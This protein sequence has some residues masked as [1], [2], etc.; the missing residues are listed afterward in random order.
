MRIAIVSP[1]DFPYPGGVTKHITNLAKSLRRR[2]HRVSIIAASSRAA[3]EIP[4]DVIRVSRFVVPVRYSGSVARISPLPWLAHRVHALLRQEAFDV[5]HLH[6]PTTP[7][8]PWAVTRHIRRVSPQTAL[9]GTFHAYRESPSLPYS[10][11][12]P[13]FWRVINGLDNESPSRQQP[14]IT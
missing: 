10:Y 4:S 11:A 13:V 3:E 5:V 7:T 8:L 12:R 1:Y 2:G 6:E 9:V 14:A